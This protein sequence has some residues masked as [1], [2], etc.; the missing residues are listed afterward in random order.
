[1]GKELKTYLCQN[2]INDV[3]VNFK[4]SPLIAE[5]TLDLY[6]SSPGLGQKQKSLWY[7][8]QQES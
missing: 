3:T 5:F 8:Q 1:M 2:M 6:L 4:M 7:F